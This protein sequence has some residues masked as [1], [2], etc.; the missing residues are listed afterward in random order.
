MGLSEILWENR[1]LTGH[2]GA[3]PCPVLDEAA[4]ELDAYFAGELRAFKVALDLVGTEFQ[5]AAWYVLAEIPYGATTT[6]GEQ[7]RRIG[8]PTAARAVGAANGRN[9]VPIVLP[10]HRVVGA[11]GSLVGFGGGLELKS[12]LLRHETRFVH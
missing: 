9:P 5:L 8:R 2:V 6:Y 7:A 4:R 12:W 10:C 1:A 3:G 11:N